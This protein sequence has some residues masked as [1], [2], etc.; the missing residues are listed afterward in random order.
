M[1]KCAFILLAAS[2]LLSSL[3]AQATEQAAERRDAR[4]VRQDTRAETRPATS[5]I[6]PDKPPPC[7]VAMLAPVPR[8]S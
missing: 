5:N 8:L 6:D 1:K 7:R 4:D 3:P 2:A